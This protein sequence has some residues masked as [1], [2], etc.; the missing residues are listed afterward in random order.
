MVERDSGAGGKDGKGQ[1]K[2]VDGAVKTGVAAGGIDQYVFRNARRVGV[3]LR[4]RHRFL[5]TDI[6]KFCDSL[7][8]L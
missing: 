1:V 4:Y 2:G 3:R 8:S 6:A 7:A 5:T